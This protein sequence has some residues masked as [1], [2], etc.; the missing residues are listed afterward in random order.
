[1][2]SVVLRKAKELA[3]SE[4]ERRSEAEVLRKAKEL[5]RSE[6]ERG[7]E[8]EDGNDTQPISEWWGVVKSLISQ[9]HESKLQYAPLNPCEGCP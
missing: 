8:A 7:S 1:M 6:Q 5:A 4:Q 3:R 2:A 9:R